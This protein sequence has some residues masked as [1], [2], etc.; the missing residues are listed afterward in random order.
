MAQLG[1]VPYASDFVSGLIIRGLGTVAGGIVGL[2]VWYM[3]SGLG[4]G[5]PYGLSAVM[6]VVIII[7]MTW[8]RLF[9]PPE[10]MAAGDHANFDDIHRGVTKLD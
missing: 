1:L 4:S 6:A 2:V 10:Q 8:W 7:I 3:G 5:N 9:A